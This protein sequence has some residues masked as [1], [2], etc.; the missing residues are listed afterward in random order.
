M[1]GKSCNEDFSSI[2]KI[3]EISEAENFVLKFD[4]KA[5]KLFKLLSPSLPIIGPYMNTIYTSIVGNIEKKNLCN[6]IMG[7]VNRELDEKFDEQNTKQVQLVTHAVLKSIRC[8]HNAKIERILDILCGAFTKQVTYDCEDLINIMAEL[9]ENEAII[10]RDI[11]IKAPK[12]DTKDNP[13][14]NIALEYGMD[15]SRKVKLYMHD[16]IKLV[17]QYNDTLYFYLNRLV[18]Y[19]LLMQGQEML[20][21]GDGRFY[22]HTEMGC[23]LFSTLNTVKS[24]QQTP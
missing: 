5:G 23:R 11:Y 18:G 1:M 3:I 6:F 10:L 9:S 19:G 16:I 2:N 12:F 8:S 7:W 22:S 4:K 14:V 13:D 21:G 24:P 15:I 17:P 20:H